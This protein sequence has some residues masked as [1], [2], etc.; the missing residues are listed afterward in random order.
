MIHR[1]VVGT[2]S[3]A[4]CFL[5]IPIAT[6]SAQEFLPVELDTNGLLDSGITVGIAENGA[7]VGWGQPAGPEKVAV[8]NGSGGTVLFDWLPDHEYCLGWDISEEGVVVGESHNVVQVGHQIKDYPYAAIWSAD[9]IPAAIADLATTVPLDLTLRQATRI[10]DQG[11]V[12]GTGRYDAT[13]ILRAFLYEGDTVTDLGSLQM[14]NGS[15]EGIDLNNQGH[16]AGWSSTDPY[17]WNHAAVWKDGTW[18]DLHDPAVIL[19]P[20]STARAINEFGVVAG[21]ADFSDDSHNWEEAAVWDHG[22]IY[23]VGKLGGLFAMCHDIND[24][25][26]AV[27]ES[28]TDTDGYHGFIYEV[29]DKMTD[30]ND[31]IPSGSGWTIVAAYQINNSGQIAALG[32]FNYITRPI[33]LIPDHDGGFRIFG[34]GCAGTDD[35]TPGLYGMGDPTANSEISLAGVNGLGDAAGMLFFGTGYDSAAFRPDCIF[36][37]LP[38]FP[39]QMPLLFKGTG[40]GA[41]GFLLQVHLPPDMLPGTINMQALLIDAGASY[42][43]SMTQALEMVVH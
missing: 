20:T 35:I 2:L 36:H 33:T 1:Y 12:L 13:S 30:L 34:S 26:I 9:G 24:H 28:M 10:N 38:L 31:L 29:G 42:G 25:G 39:L 3:L 21:S 22:T 5:F 16:V 19:G 11:Q 15:S 8:W 4:F 27:G 14:P 23:A 18:T 17:N 6:L 37:I 40:A 43:F 7:C 32:N 41:G